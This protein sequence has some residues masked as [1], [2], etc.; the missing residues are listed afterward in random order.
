MKYVLQAIARLTP[1]EAYDRQFRLKRASHCS[2]LHDIL[3]KD[4]WTKAEEVCR[5]H[6]NL[7]AASR[8]FRMSATLSPT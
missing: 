4:Q 6:K 1:R 3:P 5:L 2:V 7:G 8:S